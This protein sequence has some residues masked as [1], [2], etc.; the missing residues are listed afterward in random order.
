MGEKTIVLAVSTYGIHIT[1]PLEILFTFR[2]FEVLELVRHQT[3]DDDI[4]CQPFTKNIDGGVRSHR[5]TGAVQ[6]Y[7]IMGRGRASLESLVVLPVFLD[8]VGSQSHAPSMIV[9]PK[10]IITSTNTLKYNRIITECLNNH[11]Q[12]RV[13]GVMM[14]VATT[15]QSLVTLTRPSNHQSKLIFPDLA[16][17]PDTNTDTGK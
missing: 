7:H 5:A 16:P 11:L 9:P 4:N 8:A 1:P 2:K 15:A 3:N 6:P 12:I 17:V 14:L 13:W 10:N